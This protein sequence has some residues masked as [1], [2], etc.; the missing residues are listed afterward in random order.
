[1]TDLATDS[2]RIYF[3][4]GNEI[5]RPII[6][7]M[8]LA[9]NH[10]VPVVTDSG[11]ELIDSVK[12]KPPE[13]LIASTHLSDMDGIDALIACGK[14]HPIPSI[15]ISPTAELEKVE[16]ALQDH[17]MAYLTEPVELNDLR[18]SIYLVLTRFREFEELMK[19]NREL[20][21]ALDA[22]KWIERAKGQLMKQRE[23]DEDTAY[24]TLQR[25]AND[26]RKKLVEVAR[27]IVEAQDLLSIDG[28]Q[29]NGKSFAEG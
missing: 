13:L 16:H 17:V 23:I 7:Q 15:I 21:A 1:M 11:H 26:S 29:K 27:I 19:E 2:V 6:E 25:M 14:K 28:E 5:V 22:R 12:R 10:R 18:P 3:A 20:R 8:L 4:H 9:L 24:R